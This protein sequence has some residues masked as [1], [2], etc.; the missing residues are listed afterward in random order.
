M[1]ALKALDFN[2]G[3]S[4]EN[5]LVRSFSR[6]IQELLDDGLGLPL[7]FPRYE[8]GFNYSRDERGGGGLGKDDDSGLYSGLIESGAR[9]PHCNLTVVASP[10]CMAF[11]QRDGAISTVDITSTLATARGR[12]GDNLAPH[13]AILLDASLGR[14]EKENIL[15]KL[16]GEWEGLGYRFVVVGIQA[17]EE[18]RAYHNTEDFASPG[19]LEEVALLDSSSSWE[20]LLSRSKI[21]NFFAVEGNAGDNGKRRAAAVVA[22]RPDGHVHKIYYF[23]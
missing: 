11:D 10:K 7:L 17:K 1:L 18:G 4:T 20:Q 21:S 14:A 13:F 6:K 2:G 23:Y 9:L 22:V 3:S 16:E 8:L 15:K 5:P 12:G 19:G